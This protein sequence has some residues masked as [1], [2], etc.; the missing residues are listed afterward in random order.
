M[1]RLIPIFLVLLIIAA[2]LPAAS[3]ESPVY[4]IKTHRTLHSD[5]DVAR[6]RS[7]VAQYPEAKT[8]AD[9]IIK[10]ADSWRGRSDAWL[11]HLITPP[12]VPRAFN[13]SFT[14]CPVHG[15]EVFKHGNYSFAID[16]DR[17]FK[18]KCPIG[19]EEY[20]SND[21]Q[22][23]LDSDMKD[24]SLLTG[25]YP[26]DGRGWRKPG[27]EK[28]YWFVAY[29]NHWA[30]MN[31]I[32][33]MTRDLSRAYLL[34]GDPR[35]ARQAIILLDRIADVYP[36]MDHNK[37][38]RYAEEFVPSYTGK[39]LN[40]IWETF[41]GMQLAEAYDNVF[42]AIDSNVDAQ[43]F[44]G[45][46]GA[47]I[48]ANIERNLV[49]EIVDGVYK[50]TIRGN[51]G[52]HQE[53]LL[54]AAIVAQ[55]DL[56]GVVDGVLNTTGQGMQMEG[57]R[58][59]LANLFSRDGIS[60][61]ETAPSY[62][63]I[64]PTQLTRVAEL[65]RRS[66][67][68]LYRDPRMRQ[69]YLGPP[70]MIVQG[71]FTP[72]IGD[73][74]GVTGGSVTI[75]AWMTRI[76][77]REYGADFFDSLPG[78]DAVK[79][80]GFASY[81]DLFLEPAASAA[82]PPPTFPRPSD[83]LGGYGLAILRGRD[84]K[85]PADLSLFYGTSVGHGHADRLN[86]ELF[87]LGRKLI[88]DLGYPQFAAEDPEPPGWSRNTVSHNTVVVNAKQQTTD[89]CGEVSAF[90]SSPTVQF[91]EVDAPRAYRGE[92]EMYRRSVALIDTPAGPYAVDI[93]RVGGGS[94]HDYVLHGPE[95][96]FEVQGIDLSPPQTEGTLAGP[97][98]PYANF[99]DD[100]KRCAPNYAGP[101]Y[102]Y[103][104]SGFS[105]LTNVQRGRAENRWSARWKLPDSAGNVRITWLPQ[106]SQQVLVCDGKPPLR[107]GNPETLKYILTRRQVESS[108]P[109]R[110]AFVS[111]LE[112][113][114][115]QPAVTAARSLALKRGDPSSVAALVQTTDGDDYIA[116]CAN[117]GRLVT[118]GGL[119]F[120]GTF[121]LISH[122]GD[123]L[124]RAFLC[125][126][127]HIGV[128]QM[129]LTLD[130]GLRGRVTAV[131]Y[132]SRTVTIKPERCEASLAA[133]AGRT[134]VFKRGSRST[135]WAIAEARPGS[136]G[137]VVLRLEDLDPQT[138][139]ILV[140]ESGP[141]WVKTPNDL[142]LAGLGFYEGM[143]VADEG[144]HRLGRVAAVD[145]GRVTF[146]G[147]GAPADTD[148]DG[149]IVVRL[150]DFGVGD[151]IEVNPDAH[152][153][154][155]GDGRYR[156]ETTSGIRLSVAAAAGTRA[157]WRPDRGKARSVE[158][159]SAADTLTIRVPAGELGAGK[160]ELRILK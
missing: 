121:G 22:A 85:H 103:T 144:G 81:D 139:L 64:W 8:L 39:I 38:S 56:N 89:D 118:D 127:G 7:N 95:G 80:P 153:Q 48:R 108:A 137:T 117:G 69:L 58:Y 1:N 67:V 14:G 141:G 60:V 156:I 33:P 23:F 123:R 77:M 150:F 142:H 106:H 135:S 18:V 62:S 111:I 15:R 86:I 10:T 152:V 99:Y 160:G 143:T 129:K 124:S 109:L 61:H 30:W 17:P 149:R 26:D 134:V 98:V 43:R 65:L 83:N 63:F 93:F 71:S 74:G 82:A 42:D 75:P 16:L 11:A 159:K 140:S 40:L 21:F 13:I 59:A 158:A 12:Q 53:T 28:K 54:M 49:R 151:T 27:E 47:Q 132:A 34:T 32:L 6:A 70:R 73:C 72:A 24:R 138:A 115:Q 79:A 114:L 102:G 37:Q 35:Y 19:G 94:Q 88:P 105:F 31:H 9:S 90:A 104:G 148:G 119:D 20:P 101:F 76:A 96:E 5:E 116:S 130:E 91:V 84:A 44:L 36:G 155:I 66:G 97:N 87:A 100:P 147:G 146:D 136:E 128:G 133:L 2:A 55:Q 78:V 120:A 29:Y 45:K 50:G 157:L 122:A 3:Q 51:Y 126:A 154:R 107:P 25:P 68:D 125:G 113:Y 110:S 145:S 57:V 52:L 41:T 46:S 131:D 92:V 4:P 112:P